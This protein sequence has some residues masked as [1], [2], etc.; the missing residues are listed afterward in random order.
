MRRAA[1]RK[2]GCLAAGLGAVVLYVLWTSGILSPKRV[3]ATAASRDGS[4]HARLLHRYSWAPL[5]GS[6]EFFVDVDP[7]RTLEWV[8]DGSPWRF[9]PKR[10]AATM[11]KIGYQNEFDDQALYPRTIRWTDDRTIEVAD[12]RGRT[13]L[14]RVR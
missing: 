13:V 4:S 10:R 6:Y 7:E 5:Y 2:A 14:L 12:R 8:S 11:Q 9:A 3:I 1:R